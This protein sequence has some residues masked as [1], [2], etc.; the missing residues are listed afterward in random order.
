MRAKT[1]LIMDSHFKYLEYVASLPCCVGIGC[2]G[3]TVAHHLQTV[4]MGRSRKKPMIE[5]Y[6]TVSLCH[7]HHLAY[8]RLGRKEFE[9]RYGLNTWK[10]AH[11][12]L[13][14]WIFQETQ[15]G[16]NFKEDTR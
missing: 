2:N 4:G 12:T 11:L 16:E 1:H 5:H 14:G 15:N 8:H 7:F 3:D 10:I 13:A 9:D 6:T